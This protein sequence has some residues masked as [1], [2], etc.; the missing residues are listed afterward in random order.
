[1]NNLSIFIM[2]VYLVILIILCTYGTKEHYDATINNIGLDECSTVCK[3][4]KNCKGFGYNKDCYLSKSIVSGKDITQLYSNKFD[5]S[6]IICNKTLNYDVDELDKSTRLPDEKT[7]KLNSFYI[8]SRTSNSPESLYYNVN[9]KLHK[10]VNP[11]NIDNISDIDYYTVNEIYWPKNRFEEVITNHNATE[12]LKMYKIENIEKN[13]QNEQKFIKEESKKNINNL[14]T[15]HNLTNISN[16]SSHYNV[17]QINNNMIKDNNVYDY[18]CI[19]NIPLDDCINY[20]NNDTICKGVE[21]NPYFAKNNN[22]I[23]KNICCLKK[24][25]NNIVNRD[26]IYK[27]GKLYIKGEINPHYKN[28]SYYVSP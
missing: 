17:Y 14:Q 25:I 7:R 23:Y 21:H 9:N 1:M 18:G 8:C 12:T 15:I 11:Y 20:C 19:H 4:S 27:Y 16:A 6:N 24:D 3:K 5:P 28:I 13:K 10:V 26:D 22:E 2:I